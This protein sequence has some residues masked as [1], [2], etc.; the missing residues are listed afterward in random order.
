MEY[1]KHPL[2]KENKILKRDY[3]IKISE[4]ISRRNTLVVLPT[5][6]GKTIIALLYIADRLLEDKNFKAIIISP[7]RPLTRQHYNFFV[8]NLL[9]N[10]KKIGLVTGEVR[11]E[12]RIGTWKRNIIFTTPQTF[13]NDLIRGYLVPIEINV[14]IFD[15][16][17]HA[18]GEHPYVKISKYIL[19]NANPRIIGLTASPGYQEK[20]AE[21]MKNLFLD[22]L[23]VLTKEDEELRR[24]LPSIK[25][26]LIKA[27]IDGIYKYALNL[28]YN[29]INIK[30][31]ELKSTLG[32]YSSILLFN[33]WKNITYSRIVSIKDKI[34]ELYS[35]NEIN[36]KKRNKIKQILMELIILD[37]LATYLESYSYSSFLEY[38]NGI[39]KR[40]T[41]KWRR[42]EKS[43]MS[44]KSLYEAYILIKKLHEKG[45]LYPK[46]KATKDIITCQKGKTLIFVGLRETA[47]IIKQSLNNKGIECG[48]LI[49]QQGGM[50]Q[51][52]QIK[53]IEKFRRGLYKVLVATQVG[54]EGLDISECDS[55]IFYDNPVSSIRRVQRAGRTGRTVPGTVYFIVNPGTRDEQK[56]WAGIRSE[57][58]LFNTLK[59]FSHKIKTIKFSIEKEEGLDAFISTKDKE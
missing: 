40:A 30:I 21:I 56:F 6:T 39:I 10:H 15:E 32:K 11:P 17:H 29:L 16:A 13:Y 2:I 7:T 50:D 14:I 57:R 53:E 43:L 36:A 41:Y 42:A 22:N 35:N 8:E 54:E 47:Q 52:E 28:I 9:V 44:S 46:I 49:G 51:R 4:E 48:I 19:A 37:R 45:Y 3:Q 55:V 18:I 58:R 12:A 31:D 24:Y 27:P 5:G 20:L 38:F 33:T 25:F 1:I 26:N 23:I 59:I 34:E